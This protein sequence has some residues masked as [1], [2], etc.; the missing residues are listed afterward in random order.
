V[1]RLSWSAP[2]C[3]PVVVYRIESGGHGRPGGPQCLPVRMVGPIPRRLDA[4][5]ILLDMVTAG[6]AR[7]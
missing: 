1:T 4:T 7:A 5:G 3:P 2:G 6:A